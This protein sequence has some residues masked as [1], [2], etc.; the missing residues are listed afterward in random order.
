MSWYFDPESLSFNSPYRVHLILPA[1]Q[2]ARMK[3]TCFRGAG[4][5]KSGNFLQWSSAKELMRDSFIWHVLATKINEFLE[6]NNHE[7]NHSS[8]TLSCRI[9]FVH[10]WPIGWQSTVSTDQRG[11]IDA[12]N[13]LETFKPNNRTKAKRVKATAKDICAPITH[14]ITFVIGIRNEFIDEDVES[15]K[16]VIYAIYP[17]PDIGNIQPKTSDGW[18]RDETFFDFE[19]PGDIE[20]D[21]GPFAPKL[22]T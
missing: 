19:H 10:P 21:L 12:R 22:I 8:K 16:G 17:G 7:L 1:N 18:Y 3:N 4:I 20:G 9:T 2:K 11:L 6:C 5:A 14:E 13:D 15:F